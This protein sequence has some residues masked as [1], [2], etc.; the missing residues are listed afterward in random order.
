MTVSDTSLV[1]SQTWVCWRCSWLVVNDQIMC[2][3][4]HDY[5]THFWAHSCLQHSIQSRLR[6]VCTDRDCDISQHILKFEQ[7]NIYFTLCIYINFINSEH[8]WG[9]GWPQLSSKMTSSSILCPNLTLNKQQTNKQTNKQTNSSSSSS[10]NNHNHNYNHN[11]NKKT[12][13]LG[14]I[15]WTS[16][17]KHFATHPPWV[18][19]QTFTAVRES[20]IAISLVFYRIFVIGPRNLTYFT[21]LSLPRRCTWSGHKDSPEK[22]NWAMVMSWNF[23]AGNIMNLQ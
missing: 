2:V 6:I 1:C 23:L 3:F 10:N 9:T 15:S 4:G 13:V 5:K 11:N 22:G 16:V 14:Q 12:G 18:E 7:K 8:Q 20:I 21:R 17:C 19:L